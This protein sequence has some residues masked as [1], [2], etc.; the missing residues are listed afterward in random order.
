MS[1]L[2]RFI[3]PLSLSRIMF[4]CYVCVCWLCG[5]ADSIALIS[6]QV[7]YSRHQLQLI[8]SPYIYS[9]PSHLLCQIVV[10]VSRLCPS[11]RVESCACLVPA[12]VPVDSWIYCHRWIRLTARLHFFTLGSSGHRG[13]CATNLFLLNFVYLFISLN[14]RVITC[15]C[16]RISVV[17]IL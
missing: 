2:S 16:F 8:S 6:N 11:L 13:P 5:R 12:R 17:T 10:V 15:N 1:G 9:L 4:C 14:K 3:N 7:H